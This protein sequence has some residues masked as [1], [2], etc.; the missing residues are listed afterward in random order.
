MATFLKN[1]WVVFA[2]RIILG[3]VFLYASF[4]KIRD[5]ESFASNIQNYQMIPYSLTNLFA[6]FL[7]WLELYVGACLILGVFV[8]GAILLSAGMMVMF[9]TAISQ[10][11]ARGLDID[12][13]CF[14]QA[15]SSV[16]L[17]TLARDIVWLAMSVLVWKRDE[18]TLELFPKSRFDARKEED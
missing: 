4:D 14:K 18:K 16:G 8:D 7:P 11:I 6:I 1:K 12:C 10:A 17:D 9:I 15:G 3:V 5:P 2:F 13:G